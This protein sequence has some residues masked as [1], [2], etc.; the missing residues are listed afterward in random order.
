MTITSASFL[1]A[2][3]IVAGVIFFL[4]RGLPRQIL[5]AL[6]NAAFLSLSIPNLSSAIAMAVF[7]LSGFFVAD[8]VR[9][10]PNHRARPYLLAS[11]L[12]LLLAAFVTLKEYQFLNFLIPPGTVSRW[13]S[14]VGLSYILFRQIHYVVDVAEG[15]IERAS[16]WGYLNYQFDLFAL[17]SGPIQRYQ[18]F[19]ESWGALAPILD[20]TH[21]RLRALGRLMLGIIK[22]A[23][24]STLMLKIADHAA[25]RQLHIRSPRDW[26]AFAALFY[27]YPAY[28]YFNFS[29]YCDVVIAA[30]AF[31]GIDLPE[32]FNHPYLARN[33]IDF[34][35]RWHMTL[36]HWIRDYVFTPLYKKGV[37][38]NI[39]RPQ[40]LSYACYFIALFLAGL[41]HGSTA[42][43]A[44]FGLL[45]GAGVSV[46][47]MWEEHIIR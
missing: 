10:I 1:A 21:L 46:T 12:V 43:F 6:C 23:A 16:L 3:M 4:P 31:V 24:I 45:H 35:G 47:K 7:V 41:W 38:T 17:Y 9:R 15:Q 22:V 20:D 8:L 19:T 27:A 14:L 26:V 33:A 32:N 2:V 44:I 25:S 39:I 28:I 11:Y 29:G 18:H 40:R 42:N 37:E 5:L 30:A 34:W 13:I 36:T